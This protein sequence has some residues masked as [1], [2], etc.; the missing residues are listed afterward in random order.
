MKLKEGD[1]NQQL[2]VVILISLAK[3]KLWNV[4]QD[5]INNKPEWTLYGVVQ[6][7]KFEMEKLCVQ[8]PKMGMECNKGQIAV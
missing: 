7:I 2:P 4:R 5:V 1:S 8:N 3:A 6:C